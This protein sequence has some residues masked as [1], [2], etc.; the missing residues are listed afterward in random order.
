[1][2]RLKTFAAG[3]RELWKFIKFNISVLV[4][5]ALDIAVY[6]LILYVVFAPLNSSPLP[7]NAVLSILGIRYEGYLY[8]YLI[9]TTAGYVAAYL[10]NRKITF[11]SN[12]N[13]V[14]SSFLY[15]LLAVFNIF[16]S[17]WLGSAA[18]SFMAAADIS[19]P[20][21]EII[22]KFIIINIP[23]LWTYPAERYIIQIKR[24]TF[25]RKAND[26]CNRS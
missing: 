6:M 1:M 26:H 18:G 5:S 19:N 17:S 11:H 14:Y 25:G 16:V 3:H 8:S 22:S 24:G 4:T 13:P 7:Q 2:K 9:S 21:T 15:L 23:T 20:V 10:I 12:V